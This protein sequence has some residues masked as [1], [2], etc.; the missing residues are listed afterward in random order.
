MKYAIRP[1]SRTW[2]DFDRAF[3]DLT[4]GFF[5]PELTRRPGQYIPQVEVFENEDYYGLSFDLPGFEKENLHVEVDGNTLIVKGERKKEE[6]TEGSFYTEKVYGSFTRVF[7]LPKDAGA[8][9]IKADFKNGVLTLELKKREKAN[10]RVI[11]ILS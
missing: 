4:R 10:G 7:E 9:D 5:E 8:D 2:D 3:K 1:V 6:R 11:E